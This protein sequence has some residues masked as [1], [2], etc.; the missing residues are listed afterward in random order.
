MLLLKLYSAIC[1]IAAI[2]C[3]IVNASETKNGVAF[4]GTTTAIWLAA[5]VMIWAIQELIYE[6]R[7]LHGV[8]DPKELG[9][10]GL[11][12]RKSLYERIKGDAAQGRDDV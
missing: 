5:A 11:P 4:N 9:Q 1:I 10:L 7:K 6:L 2:I 12:K 8:T 3:T